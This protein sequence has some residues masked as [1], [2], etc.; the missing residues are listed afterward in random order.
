MTCLH[1]EK[2]LGNIGKLMILWQGIRI[3]I[4]IV[5]E[6][7]FFFWIGTLSRL[8]F[9]LQLFQKCYNTIIEKI[10]LQKTV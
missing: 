4:G 1:L 5:I 8:I 10:Q 9:R 7:F 3:Y 6:K 2:C